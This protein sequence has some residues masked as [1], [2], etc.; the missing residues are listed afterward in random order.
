MDTSS[1]AE[2]PS[3]EAGDKDDEAPG[4]SKKPAAKKAAAKKKQKKEEE[5]PNT[6]H[7]SLGNC[8]GNQD[9]DDEEGDPVP[10]ESKRGPKKK[11]EEKKERA[12]S[13]R[14][15]RK[16]KDKD[17]KKKT[18][19]KGKKSADASVSSSSDSV[20]N[21]KKEKVCES[22]LADAFKR[23]EEAETTAMASLEVG[24]SV[25]TNVLSFFK[26]NRLLC[27]KSVT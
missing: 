15:S 18:S 25:L 6:Q 14:G 20:Q 9:D 7:T 21:C 13:R 10:G 8:K 11:K 23:A 5:V 3:S 19:R 27:A 1:S 12:G 22:M 2:V 16:D 24:V 17:G 26:F 4:V